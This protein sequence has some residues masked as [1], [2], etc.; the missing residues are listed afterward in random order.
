MAPT[1]PPIS[2]ICALALSGLAAPASHA[3]DIGPACADGPDVVRHG[4]NKLELDGSLVDFFTSTARKGRIGRADTTSEYT[5][6]DC[7]TG[8]HVQVGGFSFRT[9]DVEGVTRFEETDY[10]IRAA[11]ATATM[12]RAVRAYATDRNDLVLRDLP[13]RYRER[14]LT[15]SHGFEHPPTCVCDRLE[16]AP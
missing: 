15:A 16:D 8:E 2:L 13:P 11:L 10:D 3:F 4:L 9:R 14:T 1:A 6:L 5:I 7:A 12:I